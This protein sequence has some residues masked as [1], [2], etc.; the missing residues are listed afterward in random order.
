[1]AILVFAM[2][3][4][5]AKAPLAE[6]RSPIQGSFS[7]GGATL[8]D[9]PAEEP[10]DTHLYVVIEG[11]MASSI[12]QRLEAD[13]ETDLCGDTGGLVKQGDRIVCLKLE[14]RH[15]CRFA[16]DMR[17]ETLAPGGVC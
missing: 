11:A 8:I 7:V 3:V 17:S 2:V 5:F 6:T 13:A 4:W 14:R 12:Y 15:E 9:A 16:I 1:M 10:S